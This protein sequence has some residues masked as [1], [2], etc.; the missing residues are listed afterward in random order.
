MTKQIEQ[1]KKPKTYKREVAGAMLA[2]Y[3]GMLGMGVIHYDTYPM[4]LTV[5]DQIQLEVFG[6]AAMAFGLD[7]VSK[8]IM[9]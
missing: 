4:I 9:T 1:P 3:G 6:F 5:A 2:G 7:S 8:Q